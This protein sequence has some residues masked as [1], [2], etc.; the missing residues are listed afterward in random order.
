MSKHKTNLK[1]G[2]PALTASKPNQTSEHSHCPSTILLP[3]L[4]CL[5]A[6]AT[7]GDLGASTLSDGSPALQVR[8]GVRSREMW[9]FF[10][11]QLRGCWCRKTGLNHGCS[12]TD[13]VTPLGW[14][15]RLG[16]VSEGDGRNGLTD[17]CWCLWVPRGSR[18]YRTK[19]PGEEGTCQRPKQA[20]GWAI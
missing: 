7:K 12:V 9:P 10:P 3:R 16:A 5:D 17:R 20:R 1:Q 13:S 4:T 2:A 8:T 11:R 19:V 14:G 6:A 18:S 15:W